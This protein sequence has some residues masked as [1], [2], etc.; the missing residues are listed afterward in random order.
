[1]SH[2]SSKRSPLIVPVQRRRKITVTPIVRENMIFSILI[3]DGFT[4]KEKKKAILT[5]Y[6]PLN[7][8]IKI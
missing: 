7:A 4:F 6:K 5:L 1:V 8:S 3:I 2:C